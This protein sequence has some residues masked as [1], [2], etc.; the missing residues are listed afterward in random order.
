[1][2]MINTNLFDG[3]D[4]STEVAMAQKIVNSSYNTQNTWKSPVPLEWHYGIE[5]N[6]YFTDDERP[7]WTNYRNI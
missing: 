5:G 7:N 1:M 6:S 4:I 2:V 3:V